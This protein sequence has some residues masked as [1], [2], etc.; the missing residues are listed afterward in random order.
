[1]E[2]IKLIKDQIEFEKIFDERN[3]CLI[4][5][6]KAIKSYFLL[7]YCQTAVLWRQF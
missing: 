6:F 7:P 3:I 4:I 2:F 5:Q 1:M